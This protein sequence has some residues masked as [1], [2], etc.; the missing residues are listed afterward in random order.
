MFIRALPFLFASLPQRFV[1]A[2]F[3]ASGGTCPVIDADDYVSC[4]SDSN[5]TASC[6]T[7]TCMSTRKLEHNIFE[8]DSAA[9]S[10][11]GSNDGRALQYEKTDGKGWGWDDCKYISAYQQRQYSFWSIQTPSH[12][13]LSCLFTGWKHYGC[14][15]QKDVDLKDIGLEDEIRDRWENGGGAAGD[16]I[17][18]DLERLICED[19]KR[20]GR[21][22]GGP[23]EAGKCKDPALI[24]PRTNVGSPTYCKLCYKCV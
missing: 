12:V 7:C 14:G 6:D 15:W 13:S 9:I 10:L 1:Y 22:S 2:S 19:G 21:C 24:M 5:S 11:R 18:D 8:E 23:E 17:V 20:S 16:G 3:A 4:S